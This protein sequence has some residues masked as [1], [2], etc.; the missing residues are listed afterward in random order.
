MGFG[1]LKQM[2]KPSFQGDLDWVTWLSLQQS[3]PWG[4]SQRNGI[5]HRPSA[6]ICLLNQIPLM[7]RHTPL[8]VSISK[9]FKEMQ[10]CVFHRLAYLPTGFEQNWFRSKLKAL[11]VPINHLS[12]RSVFAAA[13]TYTPLGTDPAFRTSQSRTIITSTDFLS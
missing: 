10:S 12:S 4:G 3:S 9:F 5:C 6:L 8:E 2:E 11:P 7:H 13:T 1:P